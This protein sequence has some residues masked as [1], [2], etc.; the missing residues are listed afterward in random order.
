MKTWD[1]IA[2]LILSTAVALPAVAASGRDAI[3]T[4]QVAAAISGA[5]MQTSAQQVTLL[6]NVVAATRVPA[7]K[8][9]SIE[10]WGDR[11]MKVRL[12]CAN[13]E[14]CLPFFVTVR[15]DGAN[16]AQSVSSDSD[17]SSN[18]IAR[19]KHDPKSFVVRSGTPVTLLID[20]DRVHIKLSVVCLENG[21]PGQT[22]RVASKDHKQTYQAEVV[23]GSLLRG[24]L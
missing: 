9:Q 19:T 3:T 7:L 24:R 5:G 14:E 2:T 13:P 18:A 20:G 12:G 15:G 16:A 6:T 23:D 4:A 21:A 17:R 8:V 10:R 11:G 1:L 22:I